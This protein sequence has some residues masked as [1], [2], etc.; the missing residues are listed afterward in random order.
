MCR[1]EERQGEKEG[2]EGCKYRTRRRGREKEE[3]RSE[4]E[5]E[6]GRGEVGGD[7]ERVA[8]NKHT[9]LVLEIAT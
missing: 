9:F 3:R 2:R 1:E 6:E 7:K 8:K 4:R 5:E